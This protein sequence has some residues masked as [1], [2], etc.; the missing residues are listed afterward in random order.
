MGEFYVTRYTKFKLIRFESFAVLSH[1]GCEMVRKSNF[2]LLRPELKAL[3][4][5]GM[6]VTV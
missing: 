6:S 1:V 4:S 3:S 5:T 2:E